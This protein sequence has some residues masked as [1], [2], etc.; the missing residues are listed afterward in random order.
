MYDVR[1]IDKRNVAALGSR[2][3]HTHARM[4]FL[5]ILYPSLE[6]NN[7]HR[8]QTYFSVS[9]TRRT[10]VCHTGTTPSTGNCV[11]PHSFSPVLRWCVKSVRCEVKIWIFNRTEKKQFVEFVRTTNGRWTNWCETFPVALP[12]HIFCCVHI[13][14][15]RLVYALTRSSCVQSPNCSLECSQMTF[16]H[17]LRHFGEF[18]RKRRTMST[19]LLCCVAAAAFSRRRCKR[20]VLE[21]SDVQ[22]RSNLR[23]KRVTVEIRRDI[24]Q[25]AAVFR[26][27][28]VAVLSLLQIR[29]DSSF[30]HCLHAVYNCNAFDPEILPP[31]KECVRQTLFISL[32]RHRTYL[33]L[34]R[35]VCPTQGSRRALA[36][37]VGNEVVEFEFQSIFCNHSCSPITSQTDQMGRFMRQLYNVPS[38]DYIC[39]CRNYFANMC[40]GCELWPISRAY[41]IDPPN[42]TTIAKG[43]KRKKRIGAFGEICCE[44]ASGVLFLSIVCSTANVLVF[45]SFHFLI[46]SH[47]SDMDS[48]NR[49]KIYMKLNFAKT[50]RKLSKWGDAHRARCEMWFMFDKKIE[51]EEFQSEL[52]TNAPMRR[53]PEWC[54]H[55]S[56]TEGGTAIYF[57]VPFVR[58]V[59]VCRRTSSSPIIFHLRTIFEAI[60]INDLKIFINKS[61]V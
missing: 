48:V 27:V 5:S 61:L 31:E 56:H 3:T 53:H 25:A 17:W 26:C 49:P 18:V 19:Y 11:S 23:R 30:M 33:I 6:V 15:E 57:S 46:D 58:C 42:T 2:H 55:T 43:T 59:C 40:G 44:R 37:N 16:I 13:C 4:L 8:Q 39:L 36:F 38:P 1:R 22:L 47:M 14:N 10:N 50:N 51:F 54:T 21:T 45:L 35:N 24:V 41:Q 12:V 28:F 7:S 29:F 9:S 34:W 32:S 20:K 60:K 52:C